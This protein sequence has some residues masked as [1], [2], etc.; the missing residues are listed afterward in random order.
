M[1]VGLHAFIRAEQKFETIDALVA[2]MR[3]DEAAARYLLAID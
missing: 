1:E 2:E 3:R